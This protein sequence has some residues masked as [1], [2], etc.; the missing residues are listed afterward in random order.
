MT[1][2]PINETR[3]EH[4]PLNKLTAWEG[5]VRKTDPEVGINELADSIAAHGLLQSLVVT[6]AKR[7]KFAVVAGGRRLKALQVLAADKTIE[8]DCPIPCVVVSGECDATELSLAE[9]VVRVPMHPADQFEAFRDLIDNG[10][11]TADV[12][13]RFGIAETLVLKRMKLGR[14]SPA[15]LEIYR[16]GEISLDLVQAFTV[17]DDHEAQE[18]VLADMPSWNMHP[19][20]VRRAL[21]EGELPVS[22]KRV[23][24]VGL[25]SYEAAGGRV[26]R[27][28][29]DP[30][31]GGTVLDC[32]LLDNLVAK[33]LEE[34]ADELRGEGWSWVE[35]I[36]DLGYEQMSRYSRRFPD[37]I[38][39]SEK[40]HAELEA[41]RDEYDDLVDSDEPE[42]IERCEAIDAR[43]DQLEDSGTFWPQ[44]TLAVAGAVI[45]IGYDGMRIERGLVRPGDKKLADSSKSS[46]DVS[47]AKPAVQLSAKLVEDLSAQKSAA[48]SAELMKQ[49][50]VALAAVVHALALT[51][52]YDYAGDHSCLSISGSRTNLQGALY[53]AENCSGFQ[54]LE[55]ERERIGDHLPG[56]PRELWDWCL[57]Q[58]QDVLLDVLAVIASLSLDAVITKGKRLDSTQSHHANAIGEAVLLDI[59]DY[60]TPG[61]ENFFGR[62]NSASIICAICEATG[63]DSAPA[64]HKIKKSELAIIAERKIA[65]T[66]WLPEPLRAVSA[67]QDD[68]IAAAEELPE[69]AE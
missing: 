31:E 26:R 49:P 19:N 14:V 25:D 3:I 12:A 33:A 27:D 15:I 16:K 60:F 8:K 39:L 6:K 32:E 7:G 22:D 62:T 66:G 24:L 29:F 43:L 52:F 41:L 56:N 68:V 40:D 53:D 30:E 50:D 42:A 58:P 10:A 61:A 44:E 34:A 36:P 17:V 21:T 20:V 4:V 59:G 47:D 64:W 37:D 35:I 45:G 54:A 23:R 46:A 18:R 2:E 69:A 63:S 57:E 9:N 28:L 67:A 5:N 1:N 48:L 51:V 55:T 13:A 11:S 65:G 38:P